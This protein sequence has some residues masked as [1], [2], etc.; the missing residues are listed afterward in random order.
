MDQAVSDLHLLQDPL[1]FAMASSSDSFDDVKRTF[2]LFKKK[3]DWLWLWLWLWRLT[4]FSV[5]LFRFLWIEVAEKFIFVCFISISLR[6]R[7][8]TLI[9]FY[10][11]FI[12]IILLDRCYIFFLLFINW[13]LSLLI[14]IRRKTTILVI[15]NASN[16][17]RLLSIY[18][19]DLCLWLGLFIYTSL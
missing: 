19:F 6:R 11:L 5:Y 1:V 12:C 4:F 15:I 18:L 8:N 9:S 14:F 3:K 17:Q 16:Y 10:F 2:L 7:K 13:L